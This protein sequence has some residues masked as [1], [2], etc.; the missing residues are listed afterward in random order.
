[1]TTYC[2]KFWKFCSSL[3]TTDYIRSDGCARGTII[4][5]FLQQNFVI[6]QFLRVEQETHNSSKNTIHVL[7]FVCAKKPTESWHKAVKNVSSHQKL[8]EFTLHWN[9]LQIF[10]WRLTKMSASFQAICRPLGFSKT[11]DNRATEYLWRMLAPANS[12]LVCWLCWCSGNYTVKH[13]RVFIFIWM[14]RAVMN[15]YSHSVSSLQIPL[16]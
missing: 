2:W 5:K 13:K 15:L 4:W 1:M 11:R 6:Y 8:C 9:C 7:I 10:I 3:N 12:A 14:K 16:T